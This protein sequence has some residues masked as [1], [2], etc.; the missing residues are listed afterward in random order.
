MAHLLRETCPLHNS[1]TVIAVFNA[2]IPPNSIVTAAVANLKELSPVSRPTTVR[3]LSISVLHRHPE[4]FRHPPTE[5]R[6]FR[7]QASLNL[8]PRCHHLCWCCCP[9]SAMLP[10]RLGYFDSSLSLFFW[11]PYY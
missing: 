3:D 2:D 4:G 10:L 8:P 1:S 11:L 6:C 9:F 5:T 7:S